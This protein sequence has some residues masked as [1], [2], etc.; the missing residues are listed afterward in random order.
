MQARMNWRLW[1][2]QLSGWPVF[3][4]IVTA[5]LLFMVLVAWAMPRLAH[6]SMWQNALLAV[7]ALAALAFLTLVAAALLFRK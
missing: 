5:T 7:I 3:L 2:L 1:F 4:A 6:R